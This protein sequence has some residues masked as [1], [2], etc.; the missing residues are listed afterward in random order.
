MFPFLQY[1]TP[2]PTTRNRERLSYVA[3]ND[4]PITVN[5]TNHD[6]QPQII[7][8]ILEKYGE[9]LV[10]NKKG[11]LKPKD[12]KNKCYI[13]G[14]KFLRDLVGYETRM[15]KHQLRRALIGSKITPGLNFVLQVIIHLVVTDNDKIKKDF[16]S[17]LDSLDRGPFVKGRE[18]LFIQHISNHLRQIEHISVHEDLNDNQ[19]RWAPLLLN[20]L[21]D[22]TD[23]FVYPKG[24]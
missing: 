11:Q 8:S 15:G 5:L 4:F 2:Y 3:W 17:K 7:K 16:Y 12:Y 13:A 6:F 24:D 10:K 20:R 1:V 18:Y 9:N 14:L 23:T 22:I 21:R 19:R